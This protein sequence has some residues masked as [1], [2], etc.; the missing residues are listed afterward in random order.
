MKIRFMSAVEHVTKNRKTGGSRRNEGNMN[1]N[2]HEQR[3][4][5]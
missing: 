2:R 1:K 4:E 3:R 5:K